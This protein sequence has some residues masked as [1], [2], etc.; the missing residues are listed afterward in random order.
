MKSLVD[1]WG[2]GYSGVTWCRYDSCEGGTETMVM[3]YV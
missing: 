1:V 3:E 2:S